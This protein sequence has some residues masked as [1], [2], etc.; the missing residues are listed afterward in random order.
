MASLEFNKIAAGV[1]CAGL[2]ASA[3]GQIAKILV[4][5]VHHLETNAMA[6]DI[7]AMTTAPTAEALAP[8]PLLPLL[9]SADI[10]KGEKIFKKCAACHTPDKNGANKIGPNLFDIINATKAGR[11]GFNYSGAMKEAGGNWDYLALSEFLRK[12]KN[13]M[14]GTKMTFVGLK[15]VGDRAAVIAYLRSLSDNPAPLPTEENMANE[16]SGG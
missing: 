5:P 4:S 3:S 13:Y 6:V 7:S 14:P 2:L 11:E 1:L 16:A 12:P 15:K 8:E 10:V 9:A